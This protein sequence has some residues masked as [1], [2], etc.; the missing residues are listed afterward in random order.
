MDL[1]LGGVDAAGLGEDLG[2]DPLIASGRVVAGRGFELGPV[3]REHSHLDDAGLGAEAEHLAEEVGQGLL[4]ADA[5]A[6]DRGVV[7]D[8]VGADHPEGDV[9]AAAALDPPR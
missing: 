9:L 7:G 2:G 4:V 8:L 1:V 3:D 6:G 5:E